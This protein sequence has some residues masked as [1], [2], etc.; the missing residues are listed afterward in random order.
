[1]TR[2]DD[3]EGAGGRDPQRMHRL[4]DE[5]F[6]QHGPDGGQPV[7]TARERGTPGSFEMKITD[8]AVS[9]RELSQEQG[10]PVTQSRGVTA[11]LVPG[12]R[13]RHRGGP[14]GN[15]VADEHPDSVGTA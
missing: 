8:L 14:A 12:V 15:E 4:A 9:A 1:M 2:R 13:L 10:A 11:E 7:S 6:P 5:V 3:G